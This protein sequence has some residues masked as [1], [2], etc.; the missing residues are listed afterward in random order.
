MRVRDI[1]AQEIQRG[2]IWSVKNFEANDWIDWEIERTERISS[3]DVI[4]HSAVLIE[5]NQRVYPF[6][7]SKYYEDGGEVGELAVFIEGSWVNFDKMSARNEEFEG[8]YLAHIST[9]DIHEY[10]KGVLDNRKDHKDRFNHYITQIYKTGG[11]NK[12]KPKNQLTQKF[13]KLELNEQIK[14]IRDYI[15]Q[16]NECHISNQISKGNKL[17]GKM[18]AMVDYVKLKEENHGEL[19]KLLIDTNKIVIGWMAYQLYDLFPMECVTVIRQK[20]K[21]DSLNGLGAKYWLKEH[22]YQ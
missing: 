8:P 16:I 7:I 12:F 4:L 17:V 5:G 13:I 22:G 20:A 21:E 11:I 1:S 9:L 15:A 10:Q 2:F 3:N 6:L 19:K 18:L 14:T